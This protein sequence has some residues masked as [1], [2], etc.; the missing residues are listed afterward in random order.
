MVELYSWN[1]K[2]HIASIKCFDVITDTTLLSEFISVVVHTQLLASS[3]VLQ[4]TIPRSQSA[5]I[6][7]YPVTN[8]NITT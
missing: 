3:E 6:T 1:D 5:I 2:F 7:H 8:T 4:L